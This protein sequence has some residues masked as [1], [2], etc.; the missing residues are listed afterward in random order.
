MKLQQLRYFVTV[1]KCGSVT[2]AARRLNV[3]QPAL[4]AGLRALEEELGGALLDRK[5]N[6]PRLTPLGEQFY[7]RASN[8]LKE[9][10]TAKVEFQRGLHR[11]RIRIGIL[12]TIPMHYILGFMRRFS[13]I[14][15]NLEISVREG[16]VGTLLSWLSSERVDVAVL[17]INAAAGGGWTPLF[18]EPMMLMCAYDHDM[19][20]G[21][22][23]AVR[24][25][26]D[27]AFVMRSHCERSHDAYE[28]LNGRGIRLRVVL[29]TDQDHR[30]FEAVRSHLGVTIAPASLASD[31]AAVPL[32]DF[33]LNRVVGVQLSTRVDA[34]LATDL[35]E[36]L[37]EA[38]RGELPFAHP[39]DHPIPL[40]S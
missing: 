35:I 4:S 18:E 25:L 3:S 6:S 29:R 21:T 15:P 33:G 30:A 31:V 8:I 11:P 40:R 26:D 34:A 19:A 13:A 5:R 16:G 1:F 10:D 28:I 27:Q 14:R 24:D 17:S 32:E 9:C 23:V 36:A 39:H 38:A 7:R 12:P 37:R 22:A 2:D 20:K